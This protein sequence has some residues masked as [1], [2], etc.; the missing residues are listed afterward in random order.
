MFIENCDVKSSY[1][2]TPLKLDSE[3]DD[4]IKIEMNDYNIYCSKENKLQNYEYEGTQICLIGYIF[5]IR[6]ANSSSESIIYNLVEAE[7]FYDELSYLNGRYNI[8]IQTENGCYIYSDASQLRPLVYHMESKSLASHDEVLKL[9][10]EKQGYK[11]AKRPLSNHNEFDLTRYEEIF[12]YNPSLELN[13]DS[14][15]FKRIYPRHELRNKTADESFKEL[16]PYLDETIKYLERQK[17]KIILTITAGIDSRVSAALTKSFKDNVE[18]LTYTKPLDTLNNKTAERIY[19]IDEKITRDFKENLGWNHSIINLSDYDVSKE[20]KTYNNKFFNSRHAFSLAEYYKFKKYKNILHIKS[21]VFGMGKGDFSSSLDFQEE[22]LDF[23][24]ECIH[25]I[26]EKFKSSY[27]LDEE[28]KNYFKRNIVE[29]GITK[30]R[31]YFDLFHLESR[32]GNWHS[33]LTL[34]TDPE[35]EEFIF[36]NCRKIIDIIQQPSVDERRNHRLF[37]L[38]INH[39]WPILLFFGINK[40]KNRDLIQLDEVHENHQE[41]QKTEEAQRS[42]V[43]VTGRN[44]ILISN[45]KDGYIEVKPSLVDQKISSNE[46]YS[47]DIKNLNE[48][49]SQI[50]VK[51][52]YKNRGK[53]FLMIREDGEY[54]IFDIVDLNEGTKMFINDSIISIDIFYDKDYIRSSWQKAGIIKISVLK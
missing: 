35:T 46:L 34:E 49:D 2:L 24:K 38:I 30:E 37:K 51:S 17:D 19:K 40:S 5:D 41:L 10:L 42:S 47:F 6:N 26:S 36:T 16:K 31:H 50:L 21:T 22:T 9:V 11:F 53:I 44:N 23:Y 48:R 18:Y 52:E 7:D 39:Y 3:L 12:K 43:K 20:Q 28:I 27:D 29:E 13:L 25:G 45:T 14:F 54:K 8:L 33:S 15:S 1:I 32:M 4:F